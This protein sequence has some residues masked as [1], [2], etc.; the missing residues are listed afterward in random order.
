MKRRRKELK[1]KSAD[2]EDGKQVPSSP[3]TAEA[4]VASVHE[5]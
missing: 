1:E 3:R 2:A 4:A 5:A